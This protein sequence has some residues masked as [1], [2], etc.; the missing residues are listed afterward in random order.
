MSV[1]NVL[2]MKLR[3]YMEFHNYRPLCMSL[4]Y[5]QDTGLKVC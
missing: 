5:P 2:Q 4:H 3:N 1:N